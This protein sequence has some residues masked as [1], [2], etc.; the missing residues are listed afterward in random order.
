MAG[1][2]LTLHG[3]IWV[4]PEGK[5]GR[6][7]RVI[8]IGEWRDAAY[9]VTKEMLDVWG[10]LNVKNG[11]IQR[12]VFLPSILKPEIFYDWFLKQGVGLMERNN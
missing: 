9:R 3:R 8:A 2:Q 10:G 1:F 7:E 4:I 11:F 12:S 6:L 5:S